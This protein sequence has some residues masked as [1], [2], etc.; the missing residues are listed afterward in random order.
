VAIE[1][2]ALAQR[3]AARKLAVAPFLLQTV[4]KMVSHLPAAAHQ[5]HLARSW[6]TDRLVA[7]QRLRYRTRICFLQTIGKHDGVLYRLRRTLRK[8]RKHRVRGVAE[9]RDAALG[10][11][12][13]RI[14]VVH[15]PAL[16]AG[17]RSDQ[18]LHA[19]IPALEFRGQIRDFAIGRPRLIAPVAG[20][21]DRDDVYEAAGGDRVVHEVAPGAQP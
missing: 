3:V 6:P 5:L 10:P 19:G 8:E 20:W 12:F 1:P 9:E 2:G 15:R 17:G 16:G 14:A 18:L 21:N 7:L 4:R 11:P 13:E